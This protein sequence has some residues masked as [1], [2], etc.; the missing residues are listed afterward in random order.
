ML[1]N[2]VPGAAA[3][4]FPV[5]ADAGAPGYRN[6]SLVL[7]GDKGAVA[8]VTL[9]SSGPAAPDVRTVP[10]EPGEP[11]V[12]APQ[13]DWSALAEVELQRLDTKSALGASAV[14]RTW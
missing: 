6:C 13:Q 14:F 4:S 8:K 3:I 5:W 11:V 7:T 1:I 12:I 2:L 10:L 9:Y